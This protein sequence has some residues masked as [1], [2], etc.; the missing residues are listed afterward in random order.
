MRKL[1]QGPWGVRRERTKS[2]V[3]HTSLLWRYQLSS[4]PICDAEITELPGMTNRHSD[5]DFSILA[6][7]FLVSVV[8]AKSSKM[9]PEQ[10]TWSLGHGGS[11]PP[12]PA[13]PAGGTA[14]FPASAIPELPAKSASDDSLATDVIRPAVVTPPL[15]TKDASR[16]RDLLAINASHTPKERLSPMAHNSRIEPLTCNASSTSTGHDSSL[17]STACKTSR[18]RHTPSSSHSSMESE[19]HHAR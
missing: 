7:L 8:Y 18:T 4:R 1:A 9:Q 13:A 16:A 10:H 3:F 15:P 19:A 17:G 12:V 6:A 14:A 5:L 2:L 11:S